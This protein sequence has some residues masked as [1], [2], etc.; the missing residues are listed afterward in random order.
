MPAIQLR[1]S[2]APVDHRALRARLFRPANAVFDPG[3]DLR[4]RR[5]ATHLPEPVIAEVVALPQWP[6]ELEDFNE[7]LRTLFCPV[8]PRLYF[9]APP[10]PAPPSPSSLG[11]DVKKIAA[12]HFGIT[13]AEIEGA[14]S[15]RA[16]ARPRQ[17]AMYICV[18]FAGLSTVRTGLLFGKRDHSTA[19]HAVQI[20]KT[21]IS[22]DPAFADEVSG[23]V[24]K[25]GFQE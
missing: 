25:C 6:N 17:I 15:A 5:E 24:R 12:L 3:I 14:G 18:C 4:R 16:H 13:R 9:I 21:R 23:L 10:M 7:M 22:A 8:D 11:E 20:I 1:V 19:V 2:D